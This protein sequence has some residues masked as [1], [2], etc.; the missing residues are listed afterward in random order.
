MGRNCSAAGRNQPLSGELL[1]VPPQATGGR[2]HGIGDG[3]DQRA[4]QLPALPVQRYVEV[5]IGDPHERAVAQMRCG[6]AV[7]EH[8]HPK[9]AR[10]AAANPSVVSTKCCGL[11][12]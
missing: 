11:A 6:E 2:L 7:R 5:H 4:I 9:L 3:L 10:T 1:P 12:M 8:A